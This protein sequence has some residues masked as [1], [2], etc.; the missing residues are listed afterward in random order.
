[1]IQFFNT[2]NYYLVSYPNL[3]KENDF[4]YTIVL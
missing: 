2:L 1:M 4:I 3:N